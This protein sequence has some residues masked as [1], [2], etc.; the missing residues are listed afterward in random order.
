MWL[1]KTE[2]SAYSYPDLERDGKA[3]WDG[4]SNPVALKNL[5]AMKVGERA[6]VYHT[7]KEKAA[8]GVAEVT[9]A[10]YPD[11]KAADPRLVVVDLKAVGR[12]ARPVPLA[13]LKALEVFAGSPLLRQGRLSV[14]PL[15]AAQFKAVEARG[16]G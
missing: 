9:R 3:T 8:V 2:P 10:A 4:V 11:P 7:G 6:V 13:E 1:L 15:T 16:R 12:L 14:V 5:R